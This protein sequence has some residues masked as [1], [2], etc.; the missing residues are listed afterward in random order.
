MFGRRKLPTQT[1]LY[2]LYSAH[3]YFW[4]ADTNKCFVLDMDDEDTGGSDILNT[5]HYS[6]E[7]FI[8]LPADFKAY[9][10]ILHPPCF[11]FAAFFLKN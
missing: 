10:K 11:F 7:I 3:A 2:L 9:T 6:D 4:L 5:D 8:N 1:I